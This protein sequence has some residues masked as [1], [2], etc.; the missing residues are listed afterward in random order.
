M[1]TQKEKPLTIK[2]RAFI[3]AYIKHGN[4]TQAY[5]EAGYKAS[6]NVVAGVE[7]HKLLKNPKIAKEIQ[8]FQ[9]ISREKSIA[10]AQ[11]VMEFFTKAMNG[12][13]KDQFGLE[14][15]LGDRIRAGQELAKRTIDLDNRMQ[16]KADSKVEIVVNWARK[17]GDSDVE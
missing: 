6:T 13:I 3:D 2:Q 8:S 10:T 7:G 12:E 9:T 16:G 5:I 17:K 14:A 15:T 4:A 11:D 1:N